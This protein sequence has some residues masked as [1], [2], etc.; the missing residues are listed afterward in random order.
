MRFLRLIHL[1]LGLALLAWV[2]VSAA[3]LTCEETCQVQS[4]KGFYRERPK[5]ECGSGYYR[6]CHPGSY[7]A[8]TASMCIFVSREEFTHE[9]AEKFCAERYEYAGFLAFVE[10]WDESYD[11]SHYVWNDLKQGVEGNETYFWTSGKF[12]RAASGNF[13][14]YEYRSNYFA[15]IPDALLPTSDSTR[16]DDEHDGRHC[17]AG[18]TEDYDTHHAMECN[19]KFPAVCYYY[20]ETAGCNTQLRCPLP[21]DRT[22]IT[23]PKPRNTLASVHDQATHEKLME[24]S[25]G[26]RSCRNTKNRPGS[27]CKSD[28]Y[29]ADHNDTCDVTGGCYWPDWERPCLQSNDGGGCVYQCSTTYSHDFLGQWEDGQLYNHTESRQFWAAR[30]PNA[31]IAPLWCGGPGVKDDQDHHCAQIF[32]RNR[33]QFAGGMEY[34]AGKWNDYYYWE[35]NRGYVCQ[36]DALRSTTGSLNDEL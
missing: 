2:G 28:A 33:D 21:D 26:R 13:W 27:V 5:C 17:I 7:Y 29:N 3:S 34:Y 25:G 18:H 4:Q 32:P 6:P 16:E 19:R 15:E 9:E 35:R 23:P 11:I 10:N 14:L 31:V 24:P 12:S 36:R 22:I 30:E 20:R 1:L 8:H